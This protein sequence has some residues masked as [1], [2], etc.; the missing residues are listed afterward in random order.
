MREAGSIVSFTLIINGAVCLALVA[1]ENDK[2]VVAPPSDNMEEISDTHSDTD[3]DSDVDTEADAGPDTET[4]WPIDEQCD[5][6][7]GACLPFDMACVNYDL[8]LC[9]DG[10]MCCW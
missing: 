1:C 8:M 3:G 9:G 6:L 7:N 10:F 5:A 2:V 4:N